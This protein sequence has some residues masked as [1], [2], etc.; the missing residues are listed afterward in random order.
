MN[1][2]P[3]LETQE[4]WITKGYGNFYRPSQTCPAHLIE[5]DGKEDVAHGDFCSL[6]PDHPSCKSGTRGPAP[7]DLRPPDN[8]PSPPHKTAFEQYKAKRLTVWRQAEAEDLATLAKQADLYLKDGL[9]ARYRSVK[10]GDK[11]DAPGTK[12]YCGLI[13]AKNSYGGYTGFRKFYF[14][15]IGFMAIEDEYNGSF[16]DKH[17]R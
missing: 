14:A 6:Q 10:V 12:Q 4:F 8:S 11:E 1:G 5:W 17:C 7:E 2:F 16:I 3:V 13:N 15:E 9:G